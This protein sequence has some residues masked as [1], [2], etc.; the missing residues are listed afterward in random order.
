M[1]A[2]Q[3]LRSRL[4]RDRQEFVATLPES[5]RGLLFLR[6]PGMV[7]DR[8][9]PQATIGVYHASPLEAPASPYA[10]FFIEAGH[11]VALPW[12]SHRTA[13]ME[14]RAWRDPFTEHDLEPGPF[15]VLQPAAE[16][17][18]VI[19]DILF[20]PLLGFTPDGVRLGQGGGHYDRWLGSSPETIA[21]GLAWDCQLLD[22]LPV[23]P[24][25]HPMA[26]VITPTRLFGAL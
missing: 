26:A 7:M 3:E 22:S 1:D 12:F 13:A 15:G 2:K 18:Q 11:R 4:R 16:A 8:I 23:E 19:P 24:H 20:M 21:V 5:V 9:A 25:D 14:F 17:A 6:P 10:R